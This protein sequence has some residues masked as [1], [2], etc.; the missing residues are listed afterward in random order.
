M[1]ATNSRIVT[2][3][4]YERLWRLIEPIMA[5]GK[6][7]AVVDRLVRRLK[8]AQL[9]PSDVISKH[10]VT[11]NS[12]ILLTNLANN[13]QTEIQLTYPKDEDRLRTKI[14]IFSD[15]GVELLGSQKGEVAAWQTPLGWGQFSVE[16]ILYQPEAARE[17]QL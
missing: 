13:K 16:E 6:T 5:K 1:N 17:Y 3:L 9:V 7:P 4:D 14:S 8:I 12:R 15:I 11:M 10:V 2:L